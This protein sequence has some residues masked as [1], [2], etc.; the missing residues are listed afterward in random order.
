M[1]M[2]VIRQALLYDLA[3]KILTFGRERRLRARL[4][5]PAQLRANESVLDVGC[6]T[7]T[8]ALHA[9]RQVGDGNVA[10][11]DASPEMI[12]RARHKAR[13]ANLAVHFE[14]AFARQMPFANAS[15]DV[16]LCTVAL[17]HIPRTDRPASVA[18][19]KRVVKPGG[20][21]ML[22][23]FV[24]GKRHSVAGFLHHHVG[25]RTNDLR[26]L[27][28]EAGLQVV[29]SGP[30]GMLDLHYVLARA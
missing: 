3:L 17:H 10:G 11:I 5:Q 6:G 4:L 13:K 29:E 30:L 23:D 2:A 15:F 25:L 7:G 14:Q 9:K 20:R 12:A 26:A 19:M 22:A 28:A 24:F 16:V 21:V 1:K 27:A 8:L 18:E